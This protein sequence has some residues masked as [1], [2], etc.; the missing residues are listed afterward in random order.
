MDVR[1][2]SPFI[3]TNTLQNK[4]KYTPAQAQDTFKQALSK[5]IKDVNELQNVS[6]HKTDLL[7]K[8]KIDNL[9]DVMITGQ[10]ASVALQV[11]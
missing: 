10:K 4:P 1:I 6:A 7:A 9:H 8:G 11:Q 5:A 2:Q 3:Q